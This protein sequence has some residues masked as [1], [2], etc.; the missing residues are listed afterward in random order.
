[1]VI[2][3][4]IQ[5]Y[6][7]SIYSISFSN[8]QILKYVTNRQD[9]SYKF[10]STMSNKRCRKVAVSKAYLQVIGSGSDLGCTSILLVTDCNRYLFNCGE[11]VQRLATE[12]KFKMAKISSIFITSANWKNIGGLGGTL[13]SMQSQNEFQEYKEPIKIHTPKGISE[14]LGVIK[15]TS[16]LS[17]L[18][19]S[20]DT[21]DSDKEYKDNVI[22]VSCIPIYPNINK[23]HKHISDTTSNPDVDD[24]SF[25]SNEKR[26]HNESI[27]D[28]RIK[29]SKEDLT[30]IVSYICKIEDKP[31]T[32]NL[33]KCLSKGI[34]P[35]P[36]LGMLKNGHNITLDDGT[37]VKHEDVCGKK[38]KGVTFMIVDCPNESFID[39]FV[40]QTTFNKY[41]GKDSNEDYK[42]YCI[43]HFTPQEIIDNLKY[44][45]WMSKFDPS[46][47]HLIINNSNTCTG[48][49][50][51][52]KQQYLLNLLHPKIFPILDLKCFL[53][54]ENLE[55]Q[56]VKTDNIQQIHYAKTLQCI[57]L[58]P[59]PTFNT[60]TALTIDPDSYMKDAYKIENFATSLTELHSKINEKKILFDNEEYPQIIMLGTGSSTPSKSRNTSSILV[61]IDEDH[62]ILLDCSEGTLCQMTRL[63]GLSKIYQ[64][65]SRIKA[66]YISHIHADHHLGVIGIMQA[67]AKVTKDPIYLLIPN[68][69]RLWFNIYHKCIEPIEH[70]FK[71]ISNQDILITKY[72]LPLFIEK[73]LNSELNIK[74]IT[75]TSVRHCAYACAVALE[76]K[77]GKKIV[78]S[79]DTMPCDN[80]ID[81]GKNCDLLIHEATLQD[82]LYEE[83]VAKKHST[84][85]EAINTGEKMKAGFTLLTHFSQRHTKLP[86]LPN[87]TKF[88]LNKV[89]LAYDYMHFNLSQL[90]LLPL[91]HSCLKTLFFEYYL[92]TE[93]RIKRRDKKKRMKQIN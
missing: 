36:A 32:L 82:E 87:E 45:D 7:L 81:I 78:Y 42:P 8:L 4:K 52:Y 65:L 79:G 54:E 75:T 27:T 44:K 64:V 61:K 1:M 3:L 59:G 9:Q 35:G 18:H 50:A 70:Y 11:G 89:G 88:D 92:E 72:K 21:I 24:N 33:E 5:R 22:T 17:K 56:N 91:F 15:S 63:Y 39:S 93:D 51:I 90:E 77:N 40:N 48:S 80:I 58:R 31:G 62:I 76:F 53:P 85:S 86:I 84:V 38:E 6:A 26:I 20:V 10:Y 43:V 68:N 69:L 25:N 60:G 19:I 47:Y 2:I 29:L 83:A 66:I 46:T 34:K 67:R 37:I 14:M 55:Y 71:I 28:K 23:R 57:M 13:L 74:K 73:I 30:P 12:Y 41:Q 16:I 49:E